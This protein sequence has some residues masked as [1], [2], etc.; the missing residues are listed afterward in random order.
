M[1]ELLFNEPCHLH[2]VLYMVAS[3]STIGVVLVKEDD[4]SQEHVIYY[5]IRL[6]TSPELK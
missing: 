3:E 5:L 4:I 1:L 6:F 2:F